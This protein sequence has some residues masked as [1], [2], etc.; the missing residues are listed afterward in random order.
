MD[1]RETFAPALISVAEAA[2]LASVNKITI[3]RRIHAGQI[4]AVRV[5]EGRGPIRVL[6]GPFMSWLYDGE[7]EA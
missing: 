3:Y 5:G 4:E 1:T 7:A 2:K 6:R